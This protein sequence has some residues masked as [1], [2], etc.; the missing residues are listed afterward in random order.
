MPHGLLL[1]K[2]AMASASCSKQ[3][4][5]HLSLVKKVEVIK[6]GASVRAIAEAMGNIGKT[7]VADILKQKESIL[8]AYESNASTSKKSRASKF[9]DVDEALYEW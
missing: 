5:T 4:R 8:V 2:M 9:Y 3:K 7:Q 6:Y 1:N